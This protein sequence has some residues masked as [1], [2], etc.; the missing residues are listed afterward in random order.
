VGQP[1]DGDPKLSFGLFDT[2]RFDYENVQ[3]DYDVAAAARKIRNAEGLP[4]RL[5]DRL[6][7]G[8]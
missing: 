8:Q 4:N 7:Q 1:R 3:L 5:A 6:E 2:E